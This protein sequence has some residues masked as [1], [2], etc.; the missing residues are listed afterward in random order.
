MKPPHRA[1]GR[2]AVWEAFCGDDDL[3]RAHKVKPEELKSLSRLAMLGTFACKEDLLFILKVMRRSSPVG[4]SHRRRARTGVSGNLPRSSHSRI[5]E[6]GGLPRVI[7]VEPGRLAMAVRVL[8]A[9][10]SPLSRDIVRH[11]LQ[12]AGCEVVAEVQNASQA[13]DVFRTV[14]PQVVALEVGLPCAGGIGSFELFRTIRQE[15]PET[16]VIILTERGSAH[17]HE[18]F[19]KEGALDCLVEPFDAVG[20]RRI[21]RSLSSTYPELSRAGTAAPIAWDGAAT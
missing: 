1:H 11:S 5:G 20:F 4:N 13:V 21:L 8:I 7:D 14:R 19:V 9:A 6:R 10:G 12:F 15:A 18:A 3:K 2:K 16:S 17:D